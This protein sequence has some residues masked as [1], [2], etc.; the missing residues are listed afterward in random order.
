[1][2]DLAGWPSRRAIRCFQKEDQPHRCFFFDGPK[3]GSRPKS[4]QEP[5]RGRGGG[6]RVPSPSRCW[7]WS[8]EP[9]P[10]HRGLLQ[11]AV[12]PHLPPNPHPTHPP[13]RGYEGPGTWLT[14]ERLRRRRER[15]LPWGRRCGTCLQTLSV[16]LSA[17]LSV[18][19]S[20]EQEI[21][22]RFWKGKVTL[23]EGSWSERAGGPC[24]R[25]LNSV[26]FG[27]LYFVDARR[28]S[29]ATEERRKPPLLSVGISL[30]L[31]TED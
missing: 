26:L 15:T 19:K 27:K 10:G 5:G 21:S 25:A 6:R 24:E 9:P 23:A 14:G 18:C 4:I 31:H 12:A 16:C 17:C 1:M 29:V 11:P 28:S 2:T 30:V 3:S 20:L 8:V 7:R 13:A 22:N